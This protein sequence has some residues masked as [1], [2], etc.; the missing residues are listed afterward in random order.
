MPGSFSA[1]LSG[2]NANSAYLSVIGN[3]LANINTVGFKSSSVT[4]QDLVSQT[5]GGSSVNPM[6]VGL[7][8]TTG[9]ISPVFSQGAI[10]NTREAT[11]VAIQ[12]GG[13]FIVRGPGGMAYTRAGNFT[14]N[15]SGKLVTPDG[16]FVQGWTEVNSTTGA[17][18]T[19]G[20]PA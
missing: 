13:F 6:Q 9:S 7:G 1:G 19:T 5:V 17:V 2:L 20:Q 16:Y 15:N 10:E 8:V 3:N 11:N 12:G 14:F 18:V 4:F